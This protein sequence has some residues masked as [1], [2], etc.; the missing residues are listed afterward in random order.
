MAD[1]TLKSK[2]NAQPPVDVPPPSA[3]AAKDVRPL[4]DRAYDRLRNEKQDV[5]DEYERILVKTAGVQNNL[6]LN[7]TMKAVVNNR[8]AVITSRQWKIRIPFRKDKMLVTE[9]L[10]KI[11][12]VVL[13]FKEIGSTV[14]SLDP[15]HAGIPFAAICFMLPVSNFILWFVAFPRTYYVVDFDECLRRASGIL[16]RNRAGC[17][18]GRLVFR[19]GKHISSTR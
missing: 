4:W 5:V 16:E 19:S 1:Q 10:D 14:A 17:G 18:P 8:V 7:E 13:K 6:P 3:S 15:V 9:I 11:V 12:G 2:V